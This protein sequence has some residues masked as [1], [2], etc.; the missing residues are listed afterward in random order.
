ML[1]RVAL[2]LLALQIGGC[3][4]FR[5]RNAVE[6]YSAD[7]RAANAEIAKINAL[8]KSGELEKA[9]A[10]GIKPFQTYLDQKLLPLWQKYLAALRAVRCQTTALK[11][12]HAIILSAQHN[13]HLSLFGLRANV[14]LQNVTTLLAAHR[15]VVRQA[16][17]AR[18]RYL[19][20]LNAH[21]KKHHFEVKP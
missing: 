19:S 21:Y 15:A 5:E 1:R 10:T 16:E 20:A 4:Y 12:I 17:L 14:T 9:L 18:Q 6:R 7:L 8:E 11:E 2:L 13:V 3:Q